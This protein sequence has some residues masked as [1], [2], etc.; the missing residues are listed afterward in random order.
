MI[1]TISKVLKEKSQ[2]LS[3]SIPGP[4]P[5]GPLEYGNLGRGV[6]TRFQDQNNILVNPK[7]ISERTNLMYISGL[8]SQ[9]CEVCLGEEKG[10]VRPTEAETEVDILTAEDAR[11]AMEVTMKYFE[12]NSMHLSAAELKILKGIME[13]VERDRTK[14]ARTNAC[15]E[16]VQFKS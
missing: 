13:R 15:G 11:K 2:H 3:S 5:V 9:A 4:S 16:S 6:T 12:L 7:L 10:A 14:S 8:P 1:S